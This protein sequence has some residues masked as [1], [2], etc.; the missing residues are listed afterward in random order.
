MRRITRDMNT[1]FIDMLN[2]LLNL[3][4]DQPSFRF[5]H[6]PRSG[7]DCFRDPA[8][9]HLTTQ[10]LDIRITRKSNKRLNILVHETQAS[11]AG[12]EIS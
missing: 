11:K 9:A 12:N 1:K 3:G 7:S 6:L 10:R 2:Q 8:N 4:P 5:A